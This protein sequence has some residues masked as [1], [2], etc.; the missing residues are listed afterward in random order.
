MAKFVVGQDVLTPGNTPIVKVE[1]DPQN[2]LPKGPHV[3]Q[4]VVVDDDD[5]RSA[6]MQVTVVVADSRAP[7][8]VLEAPSAVQIGESFVLDGSRSIDAPPGVIRGFIWTMLR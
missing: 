5:L 3:F 8:A 4:L 7:T 2:P 1:I 6:P